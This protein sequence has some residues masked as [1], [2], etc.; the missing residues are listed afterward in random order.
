MLKVFAV[1]SQL[2]LFLSTGLLLCLLGST[3]DPAIAKK[4]ERGPLAEWHKGP[5]RYLITSQEAKLFRRLDS[6]ESR[7]AF[8]HRFWSRR[9]PNPITPENE[10]RYS[11]W[12]RVVEANRQFSGV[13]AGWKTDRGKIYILLGPPNDIERDYNFNTQDSSI[14]NRGLLRWH[15][16]GLENAANRAI[17]I[18]P[19]VRDNTN[20][21]KLSDEPRFASIFFD[22]NN[23][24]EQDKST[25][26]LDP[27]MTKILDQ[28][29]YPGGTL[30]TAM[31]L[32]RLQQVP[33]ERELMRAIV[34]TE[35]FV[36]TFS[37]L[38]KTHRLGGRGARDLVAITLAVPR[39]E[40]MP[41]WDGSATSL[42]QRFA[43]TAQLT[44][45]S[46]ASLGFS[47]DIPEEA[48]VT[49]PVP[50]QDDDWIRL[51]AVRPIPPGT[52]QISAVLIDRRGASAA[53]LRE[54]L[55]VEAADTKAPGVSDPILAVSLVEAQGPVEGTVPFRRGEYLMMPRM[56]KSLSRSE[57]FQLFVEIDD[58]PDAPGPVPLTWQFVYEPTEGEEGEKRAFGK[59]GSLEDGRGP[60][61][62]DIPAKVFPLGKYT[63]TFTAGAEGGPQ[64]IRTL[65]FEVVE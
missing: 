16:Q 51:Q 23:P 40:L 46:D 37:G 1:G 31:D 18:V 21:W 52:W 57:R 2:R 50:S 36:G 48:F 11:F 59:T 14:G 29:P 28:L 26:G 64:T 4:R 32:A 27:R 38:L 53:A 41:R 35:Q 34:E 15:Y 10:A 12:Q 20:E 43:A 5:V 47:I 58:A 55:I 9:D 7:I 54:K 39:A 30:G 63:I 22:I 13:K 56:T 8:I 6:Q 65:D 60:R 49:E 3:A 45:L 19:F 61:S 42:A 44:P 24:L 25:L 62:W 33:T 17:T